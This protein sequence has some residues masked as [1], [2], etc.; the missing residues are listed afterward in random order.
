MALELFKLSNSGNIFVDEYSVI[1]GEKIRTYNLKGLHSF[2]KNNGFHKIKNQEVVIG[3]LERYTNYLETRKKIQFS[4]L[5][6]EVKKRK[7]SD[8]FFEIGAY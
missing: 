6:K 4:N 3:D 1:N 2:L 5:S 7:I 8:L